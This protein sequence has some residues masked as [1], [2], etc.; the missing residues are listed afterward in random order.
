MTV[1]LELT[2]YDLF[3]E[4]NTGYKDAAFTTILEVGLFMPRA[5]EGMDVMLNVTV[6]VW[7][8]PPI[9]TQALGT[10]G[11]PLGLF[12]AAPPGSRIAPRHHNQ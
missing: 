10:R 11:S 5:A 12:T 7:E 6:A 4:T 2:V 3:T 1:T 9:Q 8:S